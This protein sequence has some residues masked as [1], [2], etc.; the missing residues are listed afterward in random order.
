MKFDLEE[1]HGLLIPRRDTFAC[2]HIRQSGRLAWNDKFNNLP[3]WKTLQPGSVVYDVGAFV[4]DTAKVFLNCKCE[5]HAFE[6][7]EE[8]FVCL[9]HNCPKAH[10]YNLALGNGTTFD[11]LKNDGG[12]M[13]GAWLRPGKR[14][15]IRLDDLK[16]ERLDVL[17]IDVE[18][19]ELEVLKG[20]AKTIPLLRPIIHIELNVNGLARFG[21]TPEEV[22]QK[23]LSLGYSDQKTVYA[24]N[25]GYNSHCD[26][27]CRYNP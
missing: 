9:L 5:V 1:I 24:Y 3:V 14:Q 27:V 15:T 4:G 17:K 12:N 25:E 10:C 21:T 18:G 20:S 22:R 16:P 7:R 6:P 19:F 26:L 2:S 23:L 13:G 8:I 11:T